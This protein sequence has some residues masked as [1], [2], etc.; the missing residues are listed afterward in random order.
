MTFF[1]RKHTNFVPSANCFLDDSSVTYKVVVENET[2]E[3]SKKV[4]PYCCAIRTS[5]H[6]SSGK[7]ETVGNIPREVSRH[8]YYFIKDEC[9]CVDGSVL[10]TNYRPS[11][12][13]S[14]GLGMPLILTFRSERFVTH[15]IMKEF[16]T[17]LYNYD[18]KQSDYAE[19]SRRR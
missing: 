11:S 16:M 14:G 18:H 8:C 13:L 7:L 2:K 17:K 19:N 1:F 9:G 12:I 5:V 10:S 4:D 6:K 3:Y 15:E